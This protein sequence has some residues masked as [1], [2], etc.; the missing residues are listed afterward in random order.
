MESVE[1]QSFPVPDA[2]LLT[3]A[4]PPLN[5]E[6]KGLFKMIAA[7]F[8]AGLGLGVGA[9]LFRELMDRTYR[10]AAQ[11]ERGLQVHCLA[12]VPH[13]ENRS[14]GE[15]SASS[16][17]WEQRIFEVP[18]GPIWYVVGSP[19]T[20]YAEALRSVKLAIDLNTGSK[21]TK[22]IGVTSTLPREGKSTMAASLAL[23]I[24][25]TGAS[26]ILLDCDLRNPTLTKTFVPGVTKGFVDVLLGKVSLND[27]LW[28]DQTGLI[29]FLPVV[30]D[31]RYFQSTEVMA[32][33]AA[34]K[35]FESLRNSYDYVIV[36]LPPLVPIVDTRAT[37]PLIDA[38]VF[39]IRWGSTKKNVVE[40][41]LGREPGICENMLGVVLN[42]VDMKLLRS[43][44]EKNSTLYQNEHYSQYGY[45]D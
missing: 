43:Y 35:F 20:A 34:K 40:H 21:S 41:A 24:G 18:Q 39:V 5:R 44:D 7:M 33:K 2:R 26:V 19:L 31:S 37:T 29:S 10:T 45:S 3:R 15:P 38:S 25:R 36:D 6:Y 32:S 28:T 42:N 4:V 11:V 12:M 14:D 23:T 30:F 1:Q 8:G 13:V 27:A 9:A 22:I 17:M 16:I